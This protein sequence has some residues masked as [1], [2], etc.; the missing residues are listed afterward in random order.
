MTT[1][2][3][4]VGSSGPSSGSSFELLG[5]SITVGRVA[6]NDIVVDDNMVSRHHARLEMRGDTYILTDLGSANGTWV[7]G[8]RTSEP[9]TLQA[10]DSIRFGKQSGFI[11]SA[12]PFLGGDETFVAEDMTPERAPTPPAAPVPPRPAA[13]GGP[14]CAAC[15][16]PNRPGVRF[17]GHCGQPM[18]VTPAPRRT[19]GLPGWVLAVG[20]GLAYWSSSWLRRWL[21]FWLCLPE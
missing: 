11:F 3:Y 7:N 12:R 14:V 1:S 5:P 16:K 17:C 15:G 13:G 18:R 21:R 6:D 20:C 4:L 19:S 9:V 2:W 8:R 10:K